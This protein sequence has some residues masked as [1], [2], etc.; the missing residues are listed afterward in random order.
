[1]DEFRNQSIEELKVL[2]KEESRKL[3]DMVNAIRATKKT[4]KPHLISAKRKEIARLL[5]ALK[6]KE[7]AGAKK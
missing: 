7:L 1:M 3:F 4:E 6:E 2:H 5:T